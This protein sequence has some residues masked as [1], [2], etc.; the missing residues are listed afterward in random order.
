VVTLPSDTIQGYYL[1]FIDTLVTGGVWA[2]LDALYITASWDGAESK[3]NLIQDLYDIS[4]TTAIPTGFTLFQ[5]WSTT[6]EASSLVTNFNP[7]TAVASNFSLNDASVGVWTLTD[8][9]ATP[10]NYQINVTT[11]NSPPNVEI[12]ANW[13]DGHTYVALNGAE[14][15]PGVRP[16]HLNGLWVVQRT[17]NSTVDLY[18]KNNLLKSEANASTSL[19][20]AVIELGF[21]TNA[22]NTAAGFIGKSLTAGQR[23]TLFNALT[24][25]L[26]SLGTPI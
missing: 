10:T 3:L 19:R 18:N 7:S 1:T 12:I 13:T 17:S 5:G 8:Q 20:N 24:T 23:T 2:L 26:T 21:S 14:F 15:D 9:I 16:T 11:T 4:I 25:L 6:T 22:V